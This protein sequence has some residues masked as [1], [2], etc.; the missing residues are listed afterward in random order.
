MYCVFAVC[1]LS[2]M[3]DSCFHLRCRLK[4]DS[5]HCYGESQVLPHS[6]IIKTSGTE[7]NRYISKFPSLDGPGVQQG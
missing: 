3:S 2:A 6:W 1:D 5:K 4:L 7:C